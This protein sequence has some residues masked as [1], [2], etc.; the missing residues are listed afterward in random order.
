MLNTVKQ[1]EDKAKQFNE[2]LNPNI[3][4]NKKLPFYSTGARALLRI[5]GKERVVA[6]SVKW[7]ISYSGAPIHTLDTP[8][9]W[10]IDVGKVS[11]MA[12]LDEFV[13]PAEGLEVGGIFSIMK[14]AVHQPMVEMQILDAMGTAIF[15]SKGMFL[16]VNGNVTMG[17]LSGW[18]AK[19]IGIAY[20]HFVNQSF[21][22]YSGLAASGNKLLDGAKSVLKNLSG[23][24]L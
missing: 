17:R 11:I 2:L 22:P 23:G 18:S 10:D 16:E 24:A 7:T 13:S 8:F 9:P 4:D 1:W 15:Y 21:K 19:F 14:S 6:N 12:S 5:G 3:P 20:Q